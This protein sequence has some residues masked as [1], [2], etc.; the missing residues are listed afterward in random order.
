[1][2]KKKIAILSN[3]TVNLLATKLG[4]Q[5]DVYI[6]DGFDMWISDIFNSKSSLYSE[7]RQS[8]IILLDGMEFR[9]MKSVDAYAQRISLWRSAIETLVDRIVDTP[10]FVSTIDFRESKIKSL[11]ERKYYY[12]LA[13]EW[14]LFVQ[15][16]V[17]RKSNVFIIDILQRILDE[18]RNNFYSNK[19][20]YIGSMPYS[21]QG[22][23]AVSEEISKAL[24]SVFESR[25]KIIALDLDNTLWGGVVGED[26]IEGI[27]LSDHKEGARFYDFQ[28]RLLEMQKRG[29][30]LAINSKNNIDDALKAI[31]NHPDM[32][33]REESFVAEKINWNDKASNIKEMETELNLTESSFVFVDDNPI[34]REVVIGQCPD[35]YVPVFPVDS[36]DLSDFAENLYSKFFMP[37]SLTD[38]DK[39]K[40]QMYQTESKRK[41]LKNNS[42][43]LDDYIKILEIKADMHLMREKERERVHQLC[44]KTNQFNLTTKR[45]TL[46]DIAN[47]EANNDI[48]IFS[49]YSSDKFGDN[50]LVGTVICKKNNEDIII[51]TFLM[52]CRVM[53]RKL[54]NVIIYS[55]V[56]FYN[57]KFKKLIGLFVSTSKNKP[58]VN[59]YE[60]LGFNIISTSEDVKTYSFDL[61][62]GYNRIDAYSEITLNGVNI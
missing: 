21:K 26:G 2:D 33:L 9:S 22:I 16:L 23:L 13:N 37:M 53:G 4:K 50:G 58:V 17:E 8:I 41:I 55:L 3:I 14:Y 40:T 5:Y 34:E 56:N 57:G 32:I 24:G 28:L 49:I 12:E 18:G 46:T 38:E 27:E 20:W 35:V 15:S 60:E 54:E 7:S 11:S 61:S 52:S 19:M 44:N 31:Q 25:K 42:L 45:Y 39:I 10:I 30:L 47:M 62:V 6:L 43:N 51:D 1:M 36:S 59:K 48:D 29:V